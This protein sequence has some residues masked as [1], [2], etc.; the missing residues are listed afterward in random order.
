[1]SQRFTDLQARA[2]S[3]LVRIRTT[4]RQTERRALLHELRA[5]I[6]ELDLEVE[7]T[8]PPFLPG[9][10]HHLIEQLEFLD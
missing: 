6:D 10:Y 7:K 2:E 1:V 8:L 4:E 9:N 5:L 3:L